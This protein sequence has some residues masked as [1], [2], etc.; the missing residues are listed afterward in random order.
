[1]RVRDLVPLALVG[2][3]IAFIVVQ[4]RA[5]PKPPAVAAPG[6]DEPVADQAAP[7]P[8]AVVTRSASAAPAP[9]RNDAEI[10]M[11]LQDGSPGTYIREILAQQE[12]MLIRW[13]ERQSNALRVWIERTSTVPNWDASYPLVAERA[14]TEWRQAGFPLEFIVV[15]DSTGSDIQIKWSVRLRGDRQIG[16]ANKT[17]DQD[18]WIVSV[19]VI[20]A[21]FNPR[22]QPMSPTLIAGVVRHEVGHALGLGHSTNPAD[23]MYPESTTP[24]ISAADRATLHLLY[25]LP[26]GVV[27]DF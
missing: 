10:R 17:R 3:I 22:G 19:E 11:K 2:G 7:P 23:V 14:F 20:V 26:P 25:R 21:T 8:V 24:V 1:M 27:K 12:Q 4:A 9:A 6:S 5:V 15:P 16:V 18:G 13:P